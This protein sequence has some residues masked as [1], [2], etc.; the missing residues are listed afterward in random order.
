MQ[1]PPRITFHQMDASPSVKVRVL[2]HIGHLERFHDRITGCHV[3]IEGPPGQRRHGA[4]FN[5]RIDLTIPGRDI[6]VRTE[7]A[8][9]PSHDDVYVALRDAFDNAK[10]QLQDEHPGAG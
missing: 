5:V 6:H 9:R 3:V 4:P 10:R 8:Q 2:E 7:G 1:T